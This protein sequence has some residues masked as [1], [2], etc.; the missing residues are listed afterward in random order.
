[1]SFAGIRIPAQSL[2][3]AQYQLQCAPTGSF[4]L[5]S[6]TLKHTAAPTAQITIECEQLQVV[7]PTLL[8]PDRYEAL[9]LDG[10]ARTVSSG[11]SR[12]RVNLLVSDAARDVLRT[13]FF[14]RFFQAILYPSRSEDPSEALMVCVLAAVHDGVGYSFTLMAAAS[15]FDSGV[16]AKGFF[17]LAEEIV[18]RPVDVAKHPYHGVMRLHFM[19]Q[20]TR[21][22][23]FVAPLDMIDT[24]SVPSSRPGATMHLACRDPADGRSLTVFPVRP[25]PSGLRKDDVVVASKSSGAWFVGS[26][27]G[28]DVLARVAAQQCLE[29]PLTS[30][31]VPRVLPLN[32]IALAPA[33]YHSAHL[34]FPML[35]PLRCFVV[36]HRLASFMVADATTTTA[37]VVSNY[38]EG[39]ATVTSVS[40]FAAAAAAAL[41]PPVSSGD[42]KLPPP[43]LAEVQLSRIALKVAYFSSHAASMKADFVSQLD[44]VVDD[45]F[46]VPAA[47]PPNG[48]VSSGS[49]H[50]SIGGIAESPVLT[51]AGFSKVLGPQYWTRLMVKYIHVLRP[52]GGRVGTPRAVDDADIVGV[53]VARFTSHESLRSTID[54][55]AV[56]WMAKVRIPATTLPPPH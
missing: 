14:H 43:A 39:A 36:E 32:G 47:S 29:V 54:P 19:L 55:L 23:S 4:P 1:M 12:Y 13:A 22:W 38:D 50:P 45:R 34:T 40:M 53:F 49:L 28:G 30:V 5:L 15:E 52:A 42:V 56:P 16:L 46:E 9:L 35:H 21:A 26:G 2:I 51:L 44:S 18:W 27:T 6:M 31:D 8:L 7:D 37:C 25:R 33:E 3:E 20:K 17:S 24:G 41:L 10:I 11:G 48:L